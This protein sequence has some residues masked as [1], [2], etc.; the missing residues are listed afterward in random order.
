MLIF[1]RQFFFCHSRK[2]KENK[3][4]PSKQNPANFAPRV[5]TLRRWYKS[6]DENL[7]PESHPPERK[8]IKVKE[9]LGAEAN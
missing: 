7:V 1:P 4:K 3:T 9:T 5:Q 6:S 8:K 2:K